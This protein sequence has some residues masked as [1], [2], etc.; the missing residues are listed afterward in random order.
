MT[1]IAKYAVLWVISGGLIW[2]AFKDIPFQSV[3]EQF[4]RADYRWVLLC[5]VITFLAHWSRAMRWKMLMNSI[6]CMPSATNTTLAVWTGYFANMVI[7]RMGEFTRCGTLQKT[8]DIP[9]DKSFGT[10]LAE[11]VFDLVTLVFLIALNFLL[12][13]DRLSGFFIHFFE[14]KFGNKNKFFWLLGTIA[15]LG[16]VSIG[17]LFNKKIQQKLLSFSLIQKIWTLGAGLVDG[18]LSIRKLKNP[19][20]FLGHTVFIW[21]MYFLQAYVLFFAIPETSH[22][23]LLAGLTLLVVGSIGMTTPSQA[24][25]G[26]FHLLVGNAMVLYGLTFQNGI[27]LATFVHALQMVETIIIGGLAFFVVMLINKKK[28]ATA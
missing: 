28:T 18:L 8:D 12:E 4:K 23:G 10:V 14:E 11:R 2:Y 17:L 19:Y 9:F 7:P 27:I 22:L 16:M 5:V 13:F 24:G 21:L 26:P 15:V 1:K 20:L 6:G 25:M 3:F